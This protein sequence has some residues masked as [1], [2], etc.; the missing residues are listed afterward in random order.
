[1]AKILFMCSSFQILSMGILLKKFWITL[2]QVFL[3]HLS[4]IGIK[5]NKESSS[6]CFLQ[7]LTTNMGVVVYYDQVK[8]VK[9]IVPNKVSVCGLCGRHDSSVHPDLMIGQKWFDDYC[10]GYNIS[11][12]FGVQVSLHYHILFLIVSYCQSLLP[13]QAGNLADFV[14]SWQAMKTTTP[15]CLYHCDNMIA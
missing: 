14:N 1:M 11:L 6:S 9:I 12:P 7:K 8:S 2:W 5:P 10:I 15:G 4:D 13:F 3:L